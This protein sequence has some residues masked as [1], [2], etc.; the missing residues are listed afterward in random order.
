MKKN[1]KIYHIKGLIS[2]KIRVC[3]LDNGKMD[4]DMEEENRFGWMV[5]F[6]KDIG[7][8]MWLVARVD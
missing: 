6:M 8:I 4:K 3:I 7:K 2:L 5:P 1:S